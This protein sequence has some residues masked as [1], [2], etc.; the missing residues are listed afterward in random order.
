MDALTR[1]DLVVP[2]YRVF[3]GKKGSAKRLSDPAR[4]RRRKP[5]KPF[6]LEAPFQLAKYYPPMDKAPPDGIELLYEGDEVPALRS[7]VG[8]CDFLRKSV[9]VTF[10]GLNWDTE[11][12]RDR[13]RKVVA[14]RASVL[15]ISS[16][17]E[18]VFENDSERFAPKDWWP[19][20]SRPE[21]LTCRQ[22]VMLIGNGGTYLENVWG[23]VVEE[24]FREQFGT[25]LQMV[26]KFS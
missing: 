26:M 17:E 6:G 2:S 1:G 11:T 21:K 14:Y 13:G 25:P 3:L 8:G 12:V 18:L 24:F 4:R 23:S 10:W 19:E 16:P 7:V 22:C 15:L 9:F 5:S 20:H